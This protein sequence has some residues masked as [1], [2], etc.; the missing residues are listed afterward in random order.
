MVTDVTLF[1]LFCWRVCSL[2]TCLMN[3]LF[4]FKKR[5]RDSQQPIVLSGSGRLIHGPIDGWC[6]ARNWNTLLMSL[7]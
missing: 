7:K 5:E 2:C 1:Q 4:I 3:Y 6:K